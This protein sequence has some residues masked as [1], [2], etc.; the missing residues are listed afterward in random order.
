MEK[1]KKKKKS[2]CT[3]AESFAKGWGLVVDWCCSTP[4]L[5][6]DQQR[7]C[8]IDNIGFMEVVSGLKLHAASFAFHEATLERY[9]N[10]PRKQTCQ[11]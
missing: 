9:V 10:Q 1:K 8:N 6:R 3:S 11:C 7:M 4:L 5:G 2:C